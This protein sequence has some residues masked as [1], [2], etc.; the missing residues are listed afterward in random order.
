VERDDG[1]DVLIK[2][3]HGAANFDLTIVS[4]SVEHV[5]INPDRE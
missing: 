4:N 2:A 1:K 3:R 5:R